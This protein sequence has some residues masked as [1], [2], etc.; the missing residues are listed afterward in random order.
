[1]MVNSYG[2][3]I[4]FIFYI[5]SWFEIEFYYKIWYNIIYKVLMKPSSLKLK[6]LK[7][8]MEYTHMEIVFT[9]KIEEDS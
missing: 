6:H 7:E 3:I 5:K 8:K 4:I 9:K 2:F 1:M